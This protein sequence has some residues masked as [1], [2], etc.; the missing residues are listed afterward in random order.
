MARVMRSRMRASVATEMIR[1]C[2]ATTSMAIA[3]PLNLLKTS[4]I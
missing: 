1:N 3:F 2:G 4:I